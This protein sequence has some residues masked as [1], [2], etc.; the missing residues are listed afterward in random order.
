MPPPDVSGI[1]LLSDKDKDDIIDALSGGGA[2]ISAVVGQALGGLL[3]G[4]QDKIV[5]N[6]EDK[7]KKSSEKF[8][9]L[10]YTAEVKS[11][12]GPHMSGYYS[13]LLDNPSKFIHVLKQRPNAHPDDIYS[14]G[15]MGGT[16]LAGIYSPTTNSTV[17]LDYVLQQVLGPKNPLTNKTDP[18]SSTEWHTKNRN[19]H[20][21]SPWSALETSQKIQPGHMYLNPKALTGAWDPTQPSKTG[22]PMDIIGHELGHST[23]N[24]LGA[25]VYD[26]EGNLVNDEA[27]QR[28]EDAIY[29]FSPLQKEQAIK[30]M[31]FNKMTENAPMAWGLSMQKIQDRPD[32]WATPLGKRPTLNTIYDNWSNYGPR[33]RDKERRGAY[34]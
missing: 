23:R 32:A 28:Y 25:K 1:G 20:Q 34:W 9:D 21:G 24:L 18:I 27:I 10:E 5:R 30:H 16:A 11:K 6:F 15:S 12:L 19:P 8:G 2:E 4:Y 14:L 13:P 26:F 31:P 17:T 7:N 29:G 33:Q 3:S 22:H